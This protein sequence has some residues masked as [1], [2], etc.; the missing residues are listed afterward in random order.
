MDKEK[1]TPGFLIEV[2]REDGWCAATWFD[3]KKKAIKHENLLWEPGYLDCAT[4]PE[5]GPT[6][7]SRYPISKCTTI[8]HAVSLEAFWRSE[9][10]PTK[11]PPYT[12]TYNWVEWEAHIREY[13]QQAEKDLLDHSKELEDEA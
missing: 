3:K 12:S 7:Y 9:E 5:D 1:T 13:Q 4:P 2:R 10:P 8:R 11:P 6:S